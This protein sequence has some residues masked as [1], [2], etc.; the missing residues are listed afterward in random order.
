MVAQVCEQH[1][2][3][4]VINQVALKNLQLTVQIKHVF[5]CEILF[6]ST[7]RIQIKF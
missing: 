1:K 2:N 5:T 3:T 7:T 6:H 4:H